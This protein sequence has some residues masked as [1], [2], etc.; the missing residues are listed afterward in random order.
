MRSY[1]GLLLALVLAGCG[2]AQLAT[3]RPPAQTSVATSC[4]GLSPAQQLAAARRVLVGVMLSG[5]AIRLGGRR[6][7]GSPARMRV[8]RS[9]KGHG[10]SLVSVNT[11]VKIE[12]GGYSGNS[13]GIE[14]QAGER[15]KIYTSSRRQPFDTSICLGSTRVLAT[16]RPP[17]PGARAALRLWRGFPVRATPRPIV[18]LGE[19][20][21]LDPA[22]GFRTAAQKTAYEEGRFVLRAALPVGPATFG[23]YHVVSAATAYR[24]LRGDSVNDHEQVPPLIVTR[25]KPGTA[26]FVTD[27]GRIRL[28]AWRFFFDGVAQPA[29]VLALASPE[30]FVAPPLHRFGPPGPGNSVEDSAKEGAPGDRIEISFPGALPGTGPCEANYRASAVAGERAVAVTIT[31][32]MAPVG[33]GQACPAIAVTRTVTLHLARP[34]GARVLVSATDGGAIPVMI[35]AP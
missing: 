21:V 13:D 2:S 15:W 31:T 18:A 5:P 14:P 34:L 12:P 24:R 7:L 35:H 8:E 19:G 3:T 27:R 26:T 16:P 20:I 22:G 30:L 11:A 4:A 6:V 25:A 9:L 1:L 23:R 10:P 32:I 17:A 33:S 28:P 29:E